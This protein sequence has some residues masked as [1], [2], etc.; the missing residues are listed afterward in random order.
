MLS[1]AYSGLLAIAIIV[2]LSTAVSRHTVE[3]V[4]SFKGETVTLDA[5]QRIIA[6]A[7]KKSAEMDVKMNVTVV[8]VGGNLK[9]FVRMDDAYLGS[10]DISMKK[11][12]TAVMFGFPS[13]VL[14]TMSQPGGELYGV[15]R[16]NGGL[17]TFAGGLPL[18]NASGKLIGAIGVSGSS[19]ANDEAVAEAGAAAL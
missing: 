1:R 8:D 16:S 15:E 17:I 18:H 10:A 4:T 2:G 9:A 11:A 3:A 19:V 7:L 13:G 12:K 5:A 6:A 14:G